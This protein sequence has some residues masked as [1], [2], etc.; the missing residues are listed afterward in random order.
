LFRR[1]KEN[2]KKGRQPIRSRTAKERDRRRRHADAPFFLIFL[3]SSNETF[4]QR[5]CLEVA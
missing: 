5:F 1:K 4:A 3:F 2:K